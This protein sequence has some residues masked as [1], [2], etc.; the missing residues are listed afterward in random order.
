MEDINIDNIIDG[1]ADQAGKK[2]AGRPNLGL[3]DKHYIEKKKLNV[4]TRNIKQPDN[5]NSDLVEAVAGEVVNIDNIDQFKELYKTTCYAVLDQ[6]K[7][8]NPELVNKPPF[9]WYK[10]LL[11]KIKENTPPVSYKELDKLVA[12][13]D[14]LS[15]FLDYIGLYITF[16]TFSNLLKVY[17][18]QLEK[19]QDV[20]P[21]Y[22]DFVQKIKHERDNALLNELQYNP[23]TQGNKIFI[24]KTHGII[25]K[26]APKQIE[27]THNLRNYDNINRYRLE[28][29]Q[30]NN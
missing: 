13:W 2:R 16:E 1:L 30:K 20:N 14:V 18:Y 9:T 17:M 8:D 28:D 6:F 15:E 5:F 29:Q 22:I 4:I 7:E 26:T 23:Y 24:A 19:M 10:R 21:G 25:E 12:V 3:T 11:I 27:V